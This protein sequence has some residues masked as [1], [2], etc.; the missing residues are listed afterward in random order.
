MCAKLGEEIKNMKFYKGSVNRYTGAVVC[1]ADTFI[2]RIGYI[3]GFKYEMQG[4]R[5]GRGEEME[6]QKIFPSLLR[7]HTNVH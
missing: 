3:G 1:Q 7:S 4:R 2:K 5:R 6:D